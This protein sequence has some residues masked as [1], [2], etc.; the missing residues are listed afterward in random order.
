MAIIT[1]AV[2]ASA[3][4][5]A[6]RGVFLDSVEASAA[7]APPGGVRRRALGCQKLALNS[8]CEAL[9]GLRRVVPCGSPEGPCRR[10]T[11]CIVAA[12]PPNNN[13]GGSR[14]GEPLTRQDLVGYLASGCKPKEKWR[15]MRTVFGCALQLHVLDED[16]VLSEEL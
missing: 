1:H 11:P 15:Y 13:A 3:Q 14:S 2:V 4:V 9:G 6:A 7:A 12:S 8:S 10:R 5:A 16:E